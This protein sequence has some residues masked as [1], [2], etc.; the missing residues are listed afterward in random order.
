MNN[1]PT[2]SF[3]NPNSLGGAMSMT[4]NEGNGDD[5][6]QRWTHEVCR[7]WCT[8]QRGEQKEDK[9]QRSHQS[10]SALSHPKGS[11]A[12][13]CICGMGRIHNAGQ[14]KEE[15][16]QLQSP[17]DANGITIP[18]LTKCAA[19]SCNVHFHP[20]CALLYTKLSKNYID[21][22]SNPHKKPLSDKVRCQQ[23][24][25]ELLDVVQRDGEDDVHS[26]V[27]P[28]GFCGLHN[29]KRREEY[30]CLPC[31]DEETKVL[32]D[33]MRIPYQDG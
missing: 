5:R 2:L 24:S 16:L 25:L 15:V 22:G 12:V 10:Q 31:E 8:K 13:C 18:G 1:I 29:I 7:I 6:R 21:S 9:A 26:Y 23:F 19:T 32:F 4:I 27:V 33:S 30:G 17:Q 11:E 3:T 28:V 20:M 14:E